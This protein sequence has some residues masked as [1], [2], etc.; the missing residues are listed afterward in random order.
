MVAGGGT[1]AATGAGQFGLAALAAA[2]LV[3]T[4]LLMV[5]GARVRRPGR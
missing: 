4:G 2:A 1:L 5:R 3:L